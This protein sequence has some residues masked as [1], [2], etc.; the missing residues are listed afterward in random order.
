VILLLLE[1]VVMILLFLETVV[2]LFAVTGTPFRLL[3]LVLAVALL[4]GPAV[5]RGP[6]PLL[7]LLLPLL[8]SLFLLLLLLLFPL[9]AHD[10]SLDCLYLVDCLH[11]ALDRLFVL[12]EVRLDHSQ[13]E[14]RVHK[15]PLRLLQALLH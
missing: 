5:L 13:L 4:R 11:E 8:L 14:V 7:F 9:F 1:A 2:A 15:P 6:A 10:P 3:L 12:S